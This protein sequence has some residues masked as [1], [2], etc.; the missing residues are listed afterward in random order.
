MT[1]IGIMQGRLVPPTDNRIQCFPRERWVDEF[2]LAAQAGLDCI[3][4][5]Y[6]LYGADVNPLATDSG[7]E[8]LK[9]LSAR[10]K[11]K[12]LSICADYFMDKP[13]VRANQTELEQ[14]LNTLH[15]LLERGRLIGINRM[16]IPF[17]DTSRI[18]SQDEFDGVVMLLQCVLDETRE[19]GTE[20]HL[21]TSLAPN[22][23]AELLSRLPDPRL[24]VNYDSGNSSS[25]GYAPRDEFAAYGERVG[26]VHIKDRLLGAST[27]PLGT[28]DADFPALAE[29][30]RKV[31]YK[32]DFILQVA[33]GNSGDE[34]AWARQNRAFVLHHFCQDQ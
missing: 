11:V 15:W 27:V 34:V 1:H 28:G 33:R 13:L 21:E 9:N 7:L 24:K 26:S 32:G 12:I 6:D 23:F 18:D 10:H 25:L 4:W 17:V 2:E 31:A 22:R 8:K 5:I 29:G 20:I 16:I 3:E 14:R 19:T 30:L